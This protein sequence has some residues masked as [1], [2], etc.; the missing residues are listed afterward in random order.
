MSLSP[1]LS[2]YIYTHDVCMHV[3]MSVCIHKF[4]EHIVDTMHI[5]THLKYVYRYNLYTYVYGYGYGIGISIYIYRYG[6]G[7]GCG[8][9]LCICIYM[10]YAGVRVYA[11]VY[12]H[13]CVFYRYRW[14]YVCL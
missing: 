9:G 13:T 3:W 12:V 4:I 2:I 5:P 8:C 1:S 6:I 10:M 11:C 7:F 14:I